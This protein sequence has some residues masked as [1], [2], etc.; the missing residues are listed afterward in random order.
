MPLVV[1]FFYEGF[2]AKWS[3]KVCMILSGEVIMLP[4]SNAQCVIFLNLNS[5]FLDLSN[6]AILIYITYMK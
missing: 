6:E 5:T 4:L 2:F 1:D 3:V